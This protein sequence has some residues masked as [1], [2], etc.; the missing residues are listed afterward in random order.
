MQKPFKIYN[1]KLI[2]MGTLHLPEKNEN[3]GGILLLHGF[4]GNKIEPHRLFWKI[5]KNLELN[6]FA[7][8]RFDYRGCGES[9]GNSQ[10]F[11]IKDYISDAKKVLKKLL[12]LKGIDLNKIAVIGLSMGGIVASYLASYFKEIKKIVLLSAVADPYETFFNRPKRENP[13]FLENYKK[14]LIDFYGNLFSS[15]FFDIAKRL[16]PCEK[17][18]NFEGESL[19]I[20]GDKDETV[21]IEQMELYAKVLKNPEKVIIKNGDHTF[22]NSMQENEVISE[23]LKFLSK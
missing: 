2:I 10:D 14:G 3:F 15:K 9:E 16:K 7:S 19:L 20:Y 23:I 21:P 11:T 8:I 22:N 17:L 6:G 1:K 5:S 12:K 4:T 18:K 13:L